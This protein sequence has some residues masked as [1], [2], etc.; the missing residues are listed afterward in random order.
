MKELYCDNW[1]DLTNEIKNA[2]SIL[3]NPKKYG[4]EV[5]V[6]LPIN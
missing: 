5:K 1:K 2:K 3:G 6:I 4:L